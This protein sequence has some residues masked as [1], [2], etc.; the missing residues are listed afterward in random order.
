[1]S[2]FQGQFHSETFR[3][4]SIDRRLT[5][6]SSL[7]FF[8]FF[9]LVAC[10]APNQAIAQERVTTAQKRVIKKIGTGID[11]A[12]KLFE[13][14]KHK[15]SAKLIGELAEDLADLVKEEPSPSLLAAVQEQHARLQQAREALVAAGQSLSC[16]LYTSPSPRD[17]QKSRMPS[18]A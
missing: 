9:F 14:N 12:G 11:R 15:Q 16:L 10:L 2:E 5:I 7:W 13:N 3:I 4:S 6:A 18:S 1:M 8:L 17:R